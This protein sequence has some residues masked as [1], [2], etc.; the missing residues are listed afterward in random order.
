[1]I[2]LLKIKKEN[3]SWNVLSL[4]K[5]LVN[6]KNKNPTI[7]DLFLEYPNVGDE[8]K[9]LNIECIITLLVIGWLYSNRKS[10]SDLFRNHTKKSVAF[11]KSNTDIK[12]HKR[13]SNNTCFTKGV[14]WKS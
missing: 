8:I 1:M 4:L 13:P 3:C 6:L 14:S 11:L 2:D 7:D 10:S 9:H 5:K 12:I